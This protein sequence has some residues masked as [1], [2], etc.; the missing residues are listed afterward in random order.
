MTQAEKAAAYDV[1]VSAAATAGV[2]LSLMVAEAASYNA[3]VLAAERG[4]PTLQQ[5]DLF[6]YVSLFNELRDAAG[7]GLSDDTALAAD[8]TSWRTVKALVVVDTAAALAYLG[9]RTALW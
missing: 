7:V 8:A 5:S 1:I 2:D 9:D 6:A 4:V 3:L